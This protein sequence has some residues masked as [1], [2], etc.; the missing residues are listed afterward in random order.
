MTD[1]PVIGILTS[2]DTNGSQK[3]CIM[4]SYVRFLEQS[5]GKVVPLF[6]TDSDE[7]ILARMNQINGVLLPGGDSS[8][9]TPDG[10]P[11][12]YSLKIKVIL[13]KAKEMNERGTYFPIFAIGLSM[14]AIAAVEAPFEDTL[15]I[16]KFD[17]VDTCDKISFVEDSNESKLFRLMPDHLIVAIQNDEV[18][19]NNHHDGIFM[20]VFTKYEALN[21]SFKV[22]ATNI[23]RKGVE[24]VSIFEHIKYPFY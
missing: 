11:T 14:Q 17:S 18:T 8:V 9:L 10:V 5:G 2:P 13:E 16:G 23:D 21:S 15:T 12:I 19:Y 1:R 7:A 3:Q 22:F 6:Y 4:S 20:G 24:Y